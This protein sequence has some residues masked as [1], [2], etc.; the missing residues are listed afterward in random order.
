MRAPSI[1]ALMLAAS[2]ATAPT[3]GQPDQNAVRPTWQTLLVGQ[4]TDLTIESRAD[5]FAAADY[6]TR[7][8]WW[9]VDALDDPHS[10]DEL[11][12]PS[13]ILAGFAYIGDDDAAFIAD[14]DRRVQIWSKDFS[15]KL[16][17]YEFPEPMS[18]SAFRADVDPTGRYIAY[19]GY[20]Y[21]RE[22]AALVGEP[23]RHATQTAV[24]VANDGSVL[25]AGFHDSLIAMRDGSSGRLA[26][27]RMPDGIVSAALS[28]SGETIVATDARGRI[29]LATSRGQEPERVARAA[30]RAYLLDL[31]HDGTWFAVAAKTQLQVFQVEPFE[32]RLERDLD[33]EVTALAIDGDGTVVAGDAS[34]YIELWR[35]GD[36]MVYDRRKVA[37]SRITALAV[38]TGEGYVVA[39]SLAHGVSIHRMSLP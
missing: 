23:I 1:L 37:E 30:G 25:T 12:G 34:G 20:L 27:W 10:Y 24:D 6:G 21:D 9:R 36:P 18:G 8:R 32:R 7:V 33:A 28:Q 14:K 5:L 39:G 13:S 17:E 4:G 15:E 29:Y 26:E 2:L 35:L 19:G 16:F 22:R 3:C 11:S 38:H 31:S